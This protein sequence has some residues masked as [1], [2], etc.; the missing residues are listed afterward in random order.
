MAIVGGR[1]AISYYDSTNDDIKYVRALGL[2][3][4]SADQ[5][6]ATVQTVFSLDSQSGLATD[7]MDVGGLP[8]V[9]WYGGDLGV[10]APALE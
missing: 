7:V 3:G 2:S 4:G 6:P 8:L 5:W 1:P 10:A 9:G